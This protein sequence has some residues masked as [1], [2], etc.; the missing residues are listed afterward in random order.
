[1]CLGKE[2]RGHSNGA[3]ALL[4]RETLPEELKDIMLEAKNG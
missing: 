2:L 1:M 3:Q 4:H